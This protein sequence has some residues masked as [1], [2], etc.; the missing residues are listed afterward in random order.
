MA[1]LG[2]AGVVPG[3]LPIWPA[4]AAGL[5]AGFVYIGPRLDWGWNQYAPNP[6]DRANA[7]AAP[8][9]A[10]LTGMPPLYVSAAE[11][12]PL[13]D[14]SE[15]LAARLAMCGVDFD[16]RL[17]RGFCHACTM[18]SRMLPAADGQIAEIGDF[19]RRRCK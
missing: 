16:Y 13:R 1:L 12:D 14:G 9:N 15:R 2:A 6:A 17:L 19:L 7:L 11:L 18:M 4:R 8:L 5:T 10:D 3:L